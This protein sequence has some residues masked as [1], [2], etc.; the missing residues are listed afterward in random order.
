MGKDQDQDR[1]LTGPEQ[2]LDGALRHLLYLTDWIAAGRDVIDPV[3][4][5][6]QDVAPPT[7][8]HG[9]RQLDESLAAALQEL[10]K[11]RAK[12]AHS[13]VNASERHYR[14]PRVLGDAVRSRA[15]Q[16]AAQRAIIVEG[17]P[18]DNLR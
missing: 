14:I 9:K 8:R 7:Y 5:V 2:A 16:R 18:H 11:V 3:G 12:C 17:D 10:A 15:E 6:G 1:D 13:Y 4:E